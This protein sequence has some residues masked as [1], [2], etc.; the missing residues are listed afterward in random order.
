MARP[1]TL[2]VVDVATDHL[3]LCSQGSGSRQSGG[4]PTTT[5]EGKGRSA[6][7]LSTVQCLMLA[8]SSSPA[9]E[10][11]VSAGTT[12]TRGTT[13]IPVA[14]PPNLANPEKVVSMCVHVEAVSKRAKKLKHDV[15]R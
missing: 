7:N 5:A 4:K 13:T 15:R 6:L 12:V 14:P 10:T 1:L 2:S 11:P 9:V 8:S 3:S